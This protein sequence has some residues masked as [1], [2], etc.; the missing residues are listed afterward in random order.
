MLLIGTVNFHGKIDTTGTQKG[1]NIDYM[2]GAMKAGHGDQ[3]TSLRRNE[4]V[5]PASQ[6]SRKRH[7]PPILVT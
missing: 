2:W 3:Q 1:H 6:L 5:G 4:C 7:L